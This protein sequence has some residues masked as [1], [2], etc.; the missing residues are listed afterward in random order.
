MK[1]IPYSFFLLLLLFPCASCKRAQTIV[2]WQK[3][4][5]AYY[6]DTVPDKLKYKAAK[7]LIE[8]MDAHYALHNEGMDS[9]RL[10]MDSI[11]R[12]PHG[13]LSYYD[14]MYDSVISL[15]G[16]ALLQEPEYIYD[17]SFVTADYLI[18]NIDDAFRMWNAKWGRKYSFE[19]FCNYVLAFSFASKT[20]KPRPSR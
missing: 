10:F 6:S 12:L 17:T 3:E 11:F 5:L 2:P 19:H 20:A 18:E 4:V 8:N 16:D 13:K 9:F 7:F 1:N 14:R 15:Y